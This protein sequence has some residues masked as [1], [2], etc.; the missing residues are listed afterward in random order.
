MTGVPSLQSFPKIPADASLFEGVW[1]DIWDAGVIIYIDISIS[2]EK[3]MDD[4]L[5]EYKE[6]MAER[7][8]QT[9]MYIVSW[10]IEVI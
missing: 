6:I 1:R 2:K 9:K 4:Y 10:E 7:F 5:S 3:E 8:G